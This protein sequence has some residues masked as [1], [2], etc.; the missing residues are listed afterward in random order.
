[1]EGKQS[2]DYS[3]TEGTNGVFHVRRLRDEREL[4]RRLGT[5]HASRGWLYPR[6]VSSRASLVR[7]SVRHQVEF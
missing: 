6:V 4:E 1:M 7:T 5:R 2:D 3:N